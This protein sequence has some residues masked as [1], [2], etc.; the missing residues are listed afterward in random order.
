MKNCPICNIPL[1]PVDY[2]GLRV[3]QCL[4]CKGHLMSFA[5]LDGIKR[6]NRKSEPAL[7][8]EA[9][10]DFAGS[11]TQPLRCPRCHIV[12]DKQALDLPVLDI[13]TDVCD[14]CSLVWLDG[15][16]LALLQLAFKTSSKSLNSQKLKR[17]ISE[18]EASPER[19]A[20]FEAN[21]ARLSDSKDTPESILGSASE[22]LLNPFL[23]ELLR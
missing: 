12:M 4:T 16:E 17:R 15:G 20:A 23:R 2:E 3:W 18:L 21:L 9:S 14:G 13:H 8:S 19:K 5:R 10:T 1:T 11:T 6:A 22:M 7:K